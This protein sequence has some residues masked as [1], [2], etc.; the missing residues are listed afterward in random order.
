[1]EL[2]EK[3]TKL[4]VEY[5]EFISHLKSPEY[6][7]LLLLKAISTKNEQLAI[8][9]IYANK[10]FNSARINFS[11]RAQYDFFAYEISGK[12]RHDSN[13]IFA[14]HRSISCA[15]LSDDLEILNVYLNCEDNFWTNLHTCVIK[16][17]QAVCKGD[18]SKLK[19]QIEMLEK[20]LKRDSWAKPFNG[21]LLGIRGIYENNPAFIESGIT[22]LLANHDKQDQP[23]VLKDFFN[24]EAT[25]LAK[26]AVKSGI[27][28]HIDNSKIPTE[29]LLF[30]P[31]PSYER[32][33]A[34]DVKPEN[35]DNLFIQAE[36][37]NELI[38]FATGKG[39]YFILDR[40]YDGHNVLESWK[41][42]ILPLENT[43]AKEWMQNAIE[44]LFRAILNSTLNP[45]E[46]IGILLIHFHNYAYLK[47]EGLIKNISIDP[48]KNEILRE[49]DS[50]YSTIPSKEEIDF[51]NSTFERIKNW[52]HF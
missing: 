1:M 16:V 41:R 23:A 17:I 36:R 46:R 33:K 12:N 29:L 51:V 15:L 34:S 25:V 10:D 8:Y 18:N 30:K 37:G 9:D 13:H 43:Q 26:L 21:F 44:G 50:Y 42:Y 24:M 5:E 27:S 2:K 22:D 32:V 11:L 20:V 19:E 38:D 52:I 47:K 45:R 6:N 40:E 48:L 28:I 31:A 49:R 7:T 3:R 39:K 35:N 14:T 4:L